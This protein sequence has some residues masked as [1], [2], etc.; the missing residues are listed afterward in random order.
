M[1]DPTHEPFVKLVLNCTN[2]LQEIEIRDWLSG[3][4][5]N[6]KLAE[7]FGAWSKGDTARVLKILNPEEHAKQNSVVSATPA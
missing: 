5:A 4:H 1:V 7:A 3:N 6:E 2:Q